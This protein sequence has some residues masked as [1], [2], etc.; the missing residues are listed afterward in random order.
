MNDTGLFGYNKHN[1]RAIFDST[2]QRQVKF[3]F[4]VPTTWISDYIYSK[5]NYR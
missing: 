2:D 3:L 1:L 5:L 4:V